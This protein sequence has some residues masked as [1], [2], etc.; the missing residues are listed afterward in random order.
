MS[1]AQRPL[2]YSVVCEAAPQKK[3]DS[4]AKRARQAEKRRTYNKARKSE[5]RTR[6]K[7]VP[8][9]GWFSDFCYGILSELMKSIARE[10][11]NENESN[12]SVDNVENKFGC[13]LSE[14]Y[15]LQNLFHL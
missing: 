2:R 7:K 13:V 15:A 14:N 11:E 10:I 8:N 4:A 12:V 9:F 6:M 3:A 1:G 5:I